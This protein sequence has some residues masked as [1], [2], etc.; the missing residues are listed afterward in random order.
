M[1][2]P[3]CLPLFFYEVKERVYP[4]DGVVGKKI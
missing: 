3:S 1:Y 4:D 2:L